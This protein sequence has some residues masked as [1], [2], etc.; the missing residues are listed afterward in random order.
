[1]STKS[2]LILKAIDSANFE[3]LISGELLSNLKMILKNRQKEETFYVFGLNLST[4]SALA[5]FELLC[6]SLNALEDV[7]KEDSK[8]SYSSWKH[9]YFI[10]G[11]IG[12]YV[13]NVLKKISKYKEELTL[14]ELRNIDYALK[15]KLGKAVQS[16]I[17]KLA[18]KNN[19]LIGVWDDNFTYENELQIIKEINPPHILDLYLD[20]IS[21]KKRNF[22]KYKFVELDD[23]ID[24]VLENNVNYKDQYEEVLLKIQDNVLA[25]FDKTDVKK[26]AHKGL[27]Q[28]FKE[29]TKMSKKETL[30]TFGIYTPSEFNYFVPCGNS[31]EALERYKKEN[32]DIYDYKWMYPQWDFKLID[33]NK[34]LMDLG[35]ILG[36]MT[37]YYWTDARKI[38]FGIQE[39]FDQR[40]DEFVAGIYPIV[41]AKIVELFIPAFDIIR[42]QIPNATLTFWN[43]DAP[44]ED[45]VNANKMIN[46]IQ[47][48]SKFKR[49][50]IKSGY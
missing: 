13:M 40:Y 15:S 29:L 32:G 33:E 45:R 3:K 26:N 38:N 42:E 10:E 41:E 39:E 24:I 31:E 6:F 16:S 17:G 50:M 28:A 21:V 46:D 4:Y 7:K 20:S 12:K 22:K 5:I 36:E 43:G 27:L 44:L 25:Y 30:Y 18:T 23:E 34:H 1:M 48:V 49:E 37:M 47:K 9:N 35:D 2:K 8:W 19:I 11:K 14:E